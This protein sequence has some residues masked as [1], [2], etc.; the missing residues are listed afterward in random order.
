[1]QQHTHLNNF[2]LAE[3]P[4]ALHAFRLQPSWLAGQQPLIHLGRR[5][6]RIAHNLLAVAQS[7]LELLVLY[8]QVS[9]E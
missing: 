5:R 3:P 9:E 7:P 1:M 4:S 8:L 6:L 2:L